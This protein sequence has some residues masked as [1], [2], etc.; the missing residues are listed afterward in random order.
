[1]TQSLKHIL[2]PDTLLLSKRKGF[3]RLVLLTMS[4]SFSF[5][6]GIRDDVREET[7]LLHKMTISLSIQVSLLQFLLS[8]P[9]SHRIPLHL[10]LK[11]SVSLSKSVAFH[12]KSN[13]SHQSPKWHKLIIFAFLYN[14]HSLTSKILLFI[15]CEGIFS[16]WVIQFQTFTS[17]SETR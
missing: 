4:W 13:F 12:S 7:W 16:W 2:L 8:N 11:E 14:I 9:F 3:L 17:L 1:M 10:Y 6:L 15:R 5:P